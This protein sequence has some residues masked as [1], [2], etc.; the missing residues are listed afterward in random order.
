[1]FPGR[2][3]CAFAFPA[4]SRRLPG[5][6]AF[7]VSVVPACRRFSPRV[8]TGKRGNF[9][10]IFGIKPLFLWIYFGFKRIFFLKNRRSPHAG[11]SSRH[12]PAAWCPGEPARQKDASAHLPR[13]YKKSRN[14]LLG[15]PFGKV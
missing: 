11:Q 4:A 13:R 14:F 1:V 15:K 3:A 6:L 2:R 7:S 10:F 9:G 5:G 12:V 8:P